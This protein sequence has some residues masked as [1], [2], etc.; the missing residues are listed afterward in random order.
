MLNL[1]PQRIDKMIAQDKL[2]SL[3]ALRTP[4]GGKILAKILMML[5]VLFVII[6]F[7]P[8]QQNI[9]GVGKVTALNPM[10][11][12]QTVQTVIAGQIRK[13]HVREGQFVQKGDTIISISEVKEKYFD[14]NLL[15][16]L[17]EQIVAKKGGIQSKEQKANALERQI[18]A[19]RNTLKNKVEQTQV[20]LD[21]ERIKFE[22]AQSLYTRN[23]LLYES[24]NIPLSKFQDIESKFQASRSDY[25]AAEIEL[26]R[27]AAEYMDKISKAESDLNST[28]AE[29]YDAEAEISKMKN[30]FENLR[31]RNDQYQVLAPQNGYVVKAMLAGIGETVKEGD[32]VCTIM[33]E[34]SDMAVEMYVSAMDVPLI[35]KGRKVRIQFDGW[36][37]LQFSGWP[38]VSVGTFGGNVAVIDYVNSGPGEFRILITP[39]EQDQGW[40]PTLRVGSGIKGWVMLDDV[41]VW[42]EIWR[43]L[44]GFPPSLYQGI[45]NEKP[46]V[47][48]QKTVSSSGKK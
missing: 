18:V 17:S 8:W 41:P 44:N 26:S 34:T 42:Y 13:W 10:N 5:F 36:P 14:P 23:K 45:M 37:A 30:E 39:D 15:E 21:A 40:P 32:A 28:R 31:I 47:E 29:L 6:L 43:Q 1:S 7:F 3:R 24:G 4:D 19:L 38:S 2:Y 22:N 16:R 12:P 9:R 48:K 20:K 27:V 25:R 11:R 46:N 35:S 33:P